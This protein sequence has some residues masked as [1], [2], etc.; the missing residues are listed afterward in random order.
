VRQTVSG[1]PGDVDGD[2]AVGVNDLL[3][4]VNAWGPCPG[5]PEDLNDDGIV[6]TD[7]LLTV[8]AAWGWCR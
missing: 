4:I 1:C 6:G 3:A 8:I 5:C 7:D 2:V